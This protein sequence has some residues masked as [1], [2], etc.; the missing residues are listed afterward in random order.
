[1]ALE[2]FDASGG[3]DHEKM[4]KFM[5][6]QAIDE[7]V[8][9]AIHMCWMMLP[10]EKKNIEEV[11]KHVRKIVDRAFRDLRADSDSFGLGGGA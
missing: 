8:R 11:E 5:G 10:P 4:R 1:M 3:D 7:Q 2:K 9:S 6:P